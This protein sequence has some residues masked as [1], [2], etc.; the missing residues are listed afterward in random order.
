M[1]D[2]CAWRKAEAEWEKLG[3]EGEPKYEEQHLSLDC[4]EVDI[5]DDDE[6]IVRHHNAL[7]SCQYLWD[8]VSKIQSN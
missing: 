4:V 8:E 6:T 1:M 3:D 5:G 7:N 2:D